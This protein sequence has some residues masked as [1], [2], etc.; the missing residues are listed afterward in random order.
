[1]VKFLR[2]TL[3]LLFATGLT[4]F[5]VSLAMYRIPSGEAPVLVEDQVIYD[6][7]ELGLTNR[8]IFESIMYPGAAI[9]RFDGERDFFVTA[10]DHAKIWAGIE[11]IFEKGDHTYKAKILAPPLLFGGYGVSTLVDLQR[12]ASEPSLRK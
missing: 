8:E 1:M 12:V 10:A 9:L 2:W 4:W 6:V 5:V 7:L 3:A 11:E